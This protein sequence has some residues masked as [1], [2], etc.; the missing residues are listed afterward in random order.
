MAYCIGN[1]CYAQV[2]DNIQFTDQ[3]TDSPTSWNWSFG[4]GVTSALQNPT[5]IYSTV[6]DYSLT[7]SATNSCGTG[8][9]ANKIMHITTVPPPP[10]PLPF[11]G[12]PLEYFALA[13]MAAL[14]LMFLS[15]SQ[16]QLYKKK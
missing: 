7:H 2:N 3:S 13:G 4:D 5:H 16:P 9:C 14:G 11:T 6:G 1:D 12:I 15:Q 10:P 8:E